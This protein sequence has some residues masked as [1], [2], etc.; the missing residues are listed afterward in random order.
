MTPNDIQGAMEALDEA[1]TGPSGL[2]CDGCAV[3]C[4]PVGWQHS[5]TV[6]I[7]YEGEL[8]YQRKAL[9]M[10]WTAFKTQSGL[11]YAPTCHYFAAGRCTAHAKRPIYCRSYP[12]I[13]TSYGKRGHPEK[14]LTLDLRCPSDVNASWVRRVAAVM[15][16]LPVSDLWKICWEEVDVILTAMRRKEIPTPTPGEMVWLRSFVKSN[17]WKFA[18]TYAT[19]APHEYVVRGWMA[20]VDFNKMVR[21]TRKY[22]VMEKFSTRLHPYLYL[23]GWK[24][25]TM[26]SPVHKTTVI[27]R[28]NAD[29]GKTQK[30]GPPRTERFL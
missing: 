13:R 5:D 25:W 15:R 2:A 29:D 14:D 8:E 23:D 9:G 11:D 16:E 30:A 18:T 6:V 17:R 24:Y 22:G 4:C 28:A 12:V 19:T 7:F 3:P 20:N 1:T 27:N 26:G 10:S 21:L